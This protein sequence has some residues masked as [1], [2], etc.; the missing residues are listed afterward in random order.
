MGTLFDLRCQPQRAPCQRN[1]ECSPLSARVHFAFA[2][3]ER[4]RRA[5]G[6]AANGARRV[7]VRERMTMRGHWLKC[8]ETA[9][10]LH[11]CPTIPHKSAQS[12]AR[13]SD[14]AVISTVTEAVV[15][16]A[17]LSHRL[18]T[19]GLFPHLICNQDTHPARPGRSSSARSAC[20]Y[21][22][23]LFDRTNATQKRRHKLGRIILR[24]AEIEHADNGTAESSACDAGR[25][26]TPCQTQP[27][28]LS[29]SFLLE[30]TRPKSRRKPSMACLNPQGSSR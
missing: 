11:N 20:A 16:R 25:Q 29:L 13:S 18:R 28:N 2:A 5:T 8:N 3:A 19:Q 9:P 15:G 10:I 17:T 6:A 27:T 4:T 23:A 14:L 26:E 12:W 7:A 30:A 22:A 1:T 21:C 24:A